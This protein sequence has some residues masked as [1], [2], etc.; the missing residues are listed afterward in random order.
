LGHNYL[1][2]L[3]GLERTDLVDEGVELEGFGMVVEA[4]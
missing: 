3:K 4:D 2:Y 1:R